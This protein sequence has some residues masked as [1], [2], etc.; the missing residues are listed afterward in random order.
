[1]EASRFSSVERTIA[2]ILRVFF[3]YH[4][5]Y[6]RQL[7]HTCALNKA[8]FKGKLKILTFSGKVSVTVP[9]YEACARRIFVCVKSLFIQLFP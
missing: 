6:Q 5:F 7:L 1:M 4:S 2:I 8:S 3:F 9:L